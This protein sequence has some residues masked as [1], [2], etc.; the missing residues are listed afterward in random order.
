MRPIV[1][2]DI[3]QD[4]DAN[5]AGSVVMAVHA[6]VG[7]ETLGV[8]LRGESPFGDEELIELGEGEEVD[9]S[10]DFRRESTEGGGSERG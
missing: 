7:I 5:A 2:L 10:S 1:E 6:V 3:G 8:V 4:L 9:Q